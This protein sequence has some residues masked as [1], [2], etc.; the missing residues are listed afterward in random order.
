MAEKTRQTKRLEHINRQNRPEGGIRAEQREAGVQEGEF[1]EAQYDRRRVERL[2]RDDISYPCVEIVPKAIILYMGE[3]KGVFLPAD[4]AILL[5]ELL[6]E[7]SIACL[8]CE[9]DS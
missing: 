1:G 4:D 5:S 2:E 9:M 8:D 6:A 3:G 7:A